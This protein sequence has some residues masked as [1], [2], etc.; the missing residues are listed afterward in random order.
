M[1]IKR[2]QTF[3]HI[4]FYETTQNTSLLNFNH[5]AKSLSEEKE[6]KR[7]NFFFCATRKERS[8]SLYN[9]FFFLFRFE[10]FSYFLKYFFGLTKL[11]S[12]V[13]M[14]KAQRLLLVRKKVYLDKFFF[15]KKSAGIFCHYRQL[16][17]FITAKK[18]RSKKL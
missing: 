7:E 6:V 9:N 1:F 12:F 18:R 14:K 8:F 5:F 11:T 10:V 4:H 3:L 2:K 13:C 17:I 16:T 15:R